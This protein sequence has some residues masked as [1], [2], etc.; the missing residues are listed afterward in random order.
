MKSK[1]SFTD[2]MRNLFL[3]KQ[4][5]DKPDRK[6]ANRTDKRLTLPP[7]HVIM[8]MV[9]ILFLFACSLDEDPIGGGGGTSDVNLLINEVSAKGEDWIEIYNPESQLIDITGFQCYDGGHQADPYIFPNAQIPAMGYLVLHFNA[10]GQLYNASFGLSADGESITLADTNGDLVDHVDSPAL[11]D[12]EFYARVPN[13]GNTWQIVNTATPGMP[14]IGGVPSQT[15]FLNEIVST[16]DPD[17][18]ELYNATPS[19]IDISGYFIYD[20]G[21]SDN[22]SVFPAGTVVPA[23]G[24]LTWDCDDVQTN[25]KLSSGGEDVYLENDLEEAI[26][27]VTFPAMNDGESY[28]RIP[29]GGDWAITTTPTPGSTNGE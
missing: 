25:F 8:L 1:T 4:T 11:G 13:G 10:V 24:F 19:D 29:D 26:D 14:N 3:K 17:W 12:G 23:N 27:S 9:P 15:L 6:K 5:D 16:G 22:K 2:R 21:S 28:A 20:G 18:V 7:H